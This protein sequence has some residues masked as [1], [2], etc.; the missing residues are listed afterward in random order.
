MSRRL[1]DEHD[2]TRESARRDDP[3]AF[4]AGDQR[5]EADEEHG[6]QPTYD[7]EGAGDTDD[8]RSPWAE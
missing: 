5:V 3:D 4:P 2:R 1:K 7:P 8:E 6:G